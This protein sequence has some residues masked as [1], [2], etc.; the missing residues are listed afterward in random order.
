MYI[1]KMQRIL[2][3]TVGSDVA[4]PFTVDVAGAVESL[5]AAE[6]LARFCNSHRCA[7]A[8]WIERGDWT[9]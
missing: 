1:I 4:L 5:D 9:N 2:E 6:A 8:V 3:Q 7:V